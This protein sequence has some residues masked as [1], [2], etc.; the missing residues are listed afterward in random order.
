MYHYRPSAHTAE[1]R[2]LGHLEWNWSRTGGPVVF[3]LTSI[4]SRE[5]WKYGDRAYRYCLHDI[6]HAWQALTLA[7]RAIGCESF[8]LGHF[9]DDTVSQCCLLN[10]D[11]W[12]MLIVALHGP[13]IPLKLLDRAETVL[14][15]GRP[16]RLS[17]E[18]V[19]YPEV[20]KV[21]A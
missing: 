13:S 9:L 19:S 11:E 16:N 7:A 20:E 17:D 2:A 18:Q 15:G 14:F 4:V 12:P 8:C 3:V 21:H 5:A 1:Q 6:G 10:H